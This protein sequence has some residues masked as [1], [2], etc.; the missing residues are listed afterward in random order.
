MGAATSPQVLFPPGRDRDE[1]ALAQRL[2]AAIAQI[3][4]QRI[5]LASADHDWMH[6]QAR[7]LG[8]AHD[9]LLAQV[10]RLPLLGPAL[11][12]ELAKQARERRAQW[13]SAMKHLTEDAQ[14]GLAWDD[15]QGRFVQTQRR[16]DLHAALIALLRT[17]AAAIAPSAA[18]S[19]C[20][21][22]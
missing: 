17:P 15:A 22:W 21:C 10:G 2:R 18:P 5:L 11:A 14:A 1:Y 16:R 13:Q 9:S 8:T 7:G 12:S 3:E 4:R 20:C 6:P 19:A